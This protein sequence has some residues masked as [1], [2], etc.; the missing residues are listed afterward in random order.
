MLSCLN[1]VAGLDGQDG[2]GRSSRSVAISP[3]DSHDEGKL[4][5]Q[6]ALCTI[7][8]LAGLSSQFGFPPGRLSADAKLWSQ[9]RAPAIRV[10]G[11]HGTQARRVWT[12]NFRAFARVRVR[13]PRSLMSVRRWSTS[14]GRSLGP[15]SG[16]LRKLKGVLSDALMSRSLI[17]RSCL[18]CTDVLPVRV[19][20][21][22]N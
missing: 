13:G 4:A 5:R 22:G 21:R 1:S 20:R 15:R 14:T 9:C 8:N 10:L 18:I 3:G 16:G 19:R 12:K 7:C 2:Q 6:P 11:G 17:F